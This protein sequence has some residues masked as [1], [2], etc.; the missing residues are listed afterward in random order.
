MKCCQNG[1]LVCVQG[2]N[3]F[4]IQQLDLSVGGVSTSRMVPQLQLLLVKG[5]SGMFI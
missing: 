3:E 1:V 5:Q 4:Y 2:R